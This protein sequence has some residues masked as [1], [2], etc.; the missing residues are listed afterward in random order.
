MVAASPDGNLLW[1]PDL[2][3]DRVA[4]IDRRTG[5]VSHHF[6][7]AAPEGL[8]VAPDGSEVWLTARGSNEIVVLDS[9]GAELARFPS[10]GNFPVKLRISPDGV[11]VWVANNGSGEVAVFD[12]ASRER[13]AVILVGERPLGIGFSERSDRAFVTRPGAAEI[14][15][16]DARSFEIV[17]RIAGPASADG[18]VWLPALPVP[19]TTLRFPA[20]DGTLLFA[21]LHR[22]TLPEPQGLI[23]LF[24]QGGG[25]GR[26]E[27]RNIIP[28]L[29]EGGWDAMAVD[30]REGGDRFDG[31]NRTVQAIDEIW[32]GGYCAV[33]P[34]LETSLDV[35]RER[36]RGRIV[37]VGSSY[38]GTLSLQLAARRTEQLA[39]VAAFSP[40]SGGPLAD[41][42]AREY[43][44]GVDLP[45]LVVRPGSEA[46]MPSVQEDLA[47]FEAQGHQTWIADPGTHGASTLDPERTEGAEATWAVFER[48]LGG[49]GSDGGTDRTSGDIS[50][51]WTGVQAGAGTR[52]SPSR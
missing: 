49:I 39:G 25:S 10:A 34:D 37:V 40:A 44:A 12:R 45:I 27:F 42:L 15:E 9:V 14:V 47:A 43:T 22:T 21:D 28:R 23:L 13:L 51:G 30:L 38:S 29:L 17:R 24:H 3:G 5:E 20:A 11:Q 46:G 6:V 41:C 8:A 52:R 4:R 36:A 48:W 16:I 2:R 7:G 33:Y 32:T 1:V 18:V 26:A 31:L 19:D 50:S 35:A